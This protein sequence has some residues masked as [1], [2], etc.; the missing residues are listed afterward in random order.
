MSHLISFTTRWLARAAALFIA[1]VFLFLISGELLH[2]HSGPPTQ[3]REWA[4]IVLLTAVIVA[5]LLA[6]K[7]E[8][9]GALASLATLAA[10]VLTAGMRNYDIV[11]VLAIP[12]VLFVFDWTLRHRREQTLERRF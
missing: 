8:L 9:P 7:W 12:G 4:G 2:P 5:A 11:A 1:G 10:F 6:W 3:V